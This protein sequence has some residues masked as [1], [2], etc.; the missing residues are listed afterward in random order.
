VRVFLDAN[1][2]FSAADSQSATRQLLDEVLDRA[3]VVTSHHTLE[4]A[5][6]NL[7]MKRQ[8]HLGGLAAIQRRVK[9]TAAF[10]NRIQVQLPQEDI[11]VVAGASGSGCS[12]LWTSDRR[13]FGR[14]YGKTIG[15]I[16]VVSSIMLSDLL[17]EANPPQSRAE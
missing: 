4:E 9:T 6:R 7:Q 13:H 1:I 3:E 17:N 15:G 10:D 2:L 5:R 8:Q 16:L 11:P 12:H 14:Y